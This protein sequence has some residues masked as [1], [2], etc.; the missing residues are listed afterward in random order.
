[1]G[2]YAK[3]QRKSVEK[4]GMNPIWRG[5][6]CLL[7]VIMPMLAYWIMITILPSIIATGKVPY[8]LVGYAHFPAWVLRLKLTAGLVG[9]ISSFD[10]LWISI[11]TFIVVLL[12]IT[13][14]TSLMY[15]ILYT[16][17]GPAR[18]STLDAPPPK[19]KAKKYTR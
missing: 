2:K 9:Y 15:S 18:Y 12:F 16:M 5:I 19:H 4:K 6:G 17:V 13:A 11:I 7:I 3:Y 10:N 14:M 1:M 8:Q